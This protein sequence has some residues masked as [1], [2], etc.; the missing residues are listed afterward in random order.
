MFSTHKQITFLNVKYYTSDLV[1][2][3]SFIWLHFMG[4]FL[5]SYPLTPTKSFATAWFLLKQWIVHS[6][7]CFLS[8]TPGCR[9]I[10]SF[11]SELSNGLMSS[12]LN[13]L[14]VQASNTELAEKC[15]SP[16]MLWWITHALT[17]VSVAGEQHHKQALNEWRINA[18]LPFLLRADLK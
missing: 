1:N 14:R 2:I 18:C 5:L 4:I 6:I 7:V 8:F 16:N 10:S 11:L 15:V 17:L 3:L 13:A 12:E 9:F